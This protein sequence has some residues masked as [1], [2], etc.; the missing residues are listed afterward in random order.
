M[1]GQ[2]IR[3]TRRPDSARTHRAAWQRGS[4]AATLAVGLGVALGATPL[5][6]DALPATDGSAPWGNSYSLAYSGGELYLHT[7]DSLYLIDD[8][9]RDNITFE[10]HMTDLE[11]AFG[12]GR[13]WFEGAFATD[14]DGHALMSMG[15]SDRG[16]LRLDLA[17]QTAQTVSAFDDDNIFS[18]AGRRGGHFY[19]MWADPDFV[20]PESFTHIYHV[21]PDGEPVFAFD[22]AP[23][24]NS[25]GLAFTPDDDLIVSSFVPGGGPLG[26]NRFF[27][28]LAADLAAFEADGSEPGVELIAELTQTN[29]T[30][31]LIVDR[32]G[33]VF[34]NTTTGIGYIDPNTGDAGT[35]RGD[36]ADPDL[37]S[38]A[39]VPLDGLAYN[40]DTHELVFAEFDADIGDYHLRYAVVPEPG[41]A[42]LVAAAGL[43]VMLRRRR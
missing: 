3:T 30:S 25:G 14:A 15:Y 16:M 42:T 38:Y 43:V 20:A 26:T 40:A 23:G 28:V 2:S 39:N 12:G 33:L 34:F 10:T 7:G 32:D 41:S 36:I 18:I 27:R 37:F 24:D 13:R 9:D 29:S 19:A 1:T 6:A 11:L 31:T 35:F 4:R 22:P 21:G 8:A 17:S 5:L